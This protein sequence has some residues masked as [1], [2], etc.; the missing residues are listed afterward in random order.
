MVGGK[1][2]YECATNYEFLSVGDIVYK[3]T[4]IQFGNQDILCI[5]INCVL[6]NVLSG[7][8]FLAFWV[9]TLKGVL[10]KILAYEPCLI[11]KLQ[12]ITTLLPFSN[13]CNESVTTITE[14]AE[15]TSKVV[16]ES[17]T[18]VSSVVVST[19]ESVISA[20]ETV[21]GAKE[22]VISAGE[23]TK[24]VLWRLLYWLVN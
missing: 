9:R 17:I 6:F 8:S 14:K 20:K 2:F 12:T 13:L 1:Q 19:K 22:S 23:N 4:L 5:K 15:I 3:I 21:I 24:E 16:Q 11:I 10:F 7:K 18:K